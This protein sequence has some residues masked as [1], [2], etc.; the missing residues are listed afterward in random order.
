VNAHAGDL[1]VEVPLAQRLGDRDTVVPVAHIVAAVQFDQVDSRQIAPT[2]AGYSHPQ[3]AAAVFFTRGVELVG[4]LAGLTQ[5]A[6]DRVN[7]RGPGT[8]RM[9]AFDLAAG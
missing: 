5:A 7:R 2:Q 6:A 4:E 8:G 3:P 9:T 1:G